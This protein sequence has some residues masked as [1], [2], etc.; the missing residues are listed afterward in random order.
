[1]LTNAKMCSC[2]PIIDNPTNDCSASANWRRI[3]LRKIT[4]KEW[5]ILDEHGESMLDTVTDEIGEEGPIVE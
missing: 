5:E 2:F 1:M 4:K 3:I